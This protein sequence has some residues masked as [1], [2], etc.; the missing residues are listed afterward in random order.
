M[1]RHH[2]RIRRDD[3]GD[4]VPAE[5]LVPLGPGTV[6]QHA[7]RQRRRRHR[8]RHPDRGDAPDHDVQQ[9]PPRRPHHHHRTGPARAVP[10]GPGLAVLPPRVRRPQRA[11]QPDRAGPVRQPGPA[12]GRPAPPPGGPPVRRVRLG[13]RGRD[14]QR[15]ADLG[16]APGLLRS[17]GRLPDQAGPPESR[18]AHGRPVG[19]ARVRRGRRAG[20]GRRR[21]GRPGKPGFVSG[22]GA[23]GAGRRR[24][25][26]P[27]R[28]GL[29]GLLG[30]GNIGNDAS[31]EVVLR[32]LR[33]SHPGTVV[34]AMCR[35]PEEITAKFGIGAE[36]LLWSQRYEGRAAGLGAKALKILGKG[37][38][39]IRTAG[40]VRKHGAVIVPGMGALEASLPIKPWQTPYAMFLLTVS[41]RLTGTKT[42]M[43]SVGANQISQRVTRW[44]FDTAARAASYRSYRDQQSYDAMVQRG[45]DVSRDRVYPDLV[46]DLPAPPYQPGDPSIVGLGVMAYRG[47]NSEQD[48]ARAQEIADA[49]VAKLQ[50]FTRWLRLFVGDNLWDNTVVDAIVAD[51]RAH[52]PDLDETWVVAE[53]ITSFAELT[54]AMMPAGIVVATRYHNVMCALKLEKPVIS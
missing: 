41:G 16:R 27:P 20:V 47:T 35:G 22:P 2:R 26:G 36:P 54:Q 52:R 38:D 53:S 4:R 11:D 24:L 7:V 14:P 19:A 40:W 43:V 13:L 15:P 25:S 10:P 17:P 39:A 44:L 50:R 46:F 12:A 49:Y 1:D 37:L 31:M 18:D 3:G 45:V 33:T 30:S 29:F 5:H 48:R 9:L 23:G 51:A 34:D 32:Y 42:A 28:V 21:R 8:R 6:P